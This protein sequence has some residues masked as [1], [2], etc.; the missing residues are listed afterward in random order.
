MGNERILTR[1]P[2]Q[3]SQATDGVDITQVVYNAS[4]DSPVFDVCPMRWDCWDHVRIVDCEARFVVCN[5]NADELALTNIRIQAGQEIYY[6][7][8]QFFLTRGSIYI[9]CFNLLE[10]DHSKIEYW[11]NSIH[12][13]AR[14]SPI[15]LV[16]THLDD[17]SCTP[18]YVQKFI[19][20]IKDR[21]RKRFRN[22]LGVPSIKEVTAVSSQEK[23]KRIGVKA[24]MDLIAKI[25]KKERL[26]GKMYP[27]S[28]LRLERQ[29]RVNRKTLA[30]VMKVEEFETTAMTCG[31][32]PKDIPDVCYVL[33][34]CRNVQ[35]HIRCL[36]SC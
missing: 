26:V 18:E 23:A 15:V 2:L 13:R 12:T 9:V 3:Q 16:G 25:A 35:K 8:H 10:R 7:T 6:S 22:T 4:E 1:D 28:W 31:I 27:C 17:P 30:P 34:L 24:L 19:H 33:P 32:P 29:L 11:L 20:D 21:F 14:G 36:F 5:L